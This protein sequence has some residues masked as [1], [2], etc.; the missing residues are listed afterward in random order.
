MTGPLVSVIVPTYNRAYCL[1]STIDGVL[2]QT[3]SNLEIIV[4]DDGS[5]DDTHKLFEGRYAE[6]SRIKYF[7][8]QNAG[9]SGARNTGI[10]RA[11]GKY[12]AFCDS[13]DIWLPHKLAV[14]VACMEGFPEV[15]LSWTD[16]SAVDPDGKRLHERYTRVGYAT[17]GLFT[18]EQLFQKTARLS[19]LESALSVDGDVYVGDI[20]TPMIVGAIINI[21]TVMVRRSVMDR[22]GLFN[23]TMKVGED[24]DFD[25]RMCCEAP[26]AFVDV[27]T[28]DYRVGA[29]DQLTRPELLA[30]QAKNSLS[31]LDPIVKQHRNRIRLSNSELS[32]VFAGRYR[33]LG[34]AEMDMENFGAARSAFFRSLC[35]QP[36]QPR[37]LALFLALLVPSG[38]VSV[39]RGLF[40]KFKQL[41]G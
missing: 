37:V 26:A 32:R 12:I 36:A 39:L 33:W 34:Q 23:E 41:V 40:R 25:L 6:E 14:Q 28:I 11:T 8:Q 7:Y 18:M 30:D 29:A 9:I 4:I 21:P 38:A 20:F 3:Y 16:L 17:W 5:S 10:R 31:T 35:R 15:G 19:A 1:E 24:Y 27:V 22:V 13:D 2:A